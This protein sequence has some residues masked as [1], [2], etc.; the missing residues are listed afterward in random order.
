MITVPTWFQIFLLLPL[1]VFVF[2]TLNVVPAIVTSWLVGGFL[3]ASAR[4]QAAKQPTCAP[5]T[6]VRKTDSGEHREPRRA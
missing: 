4:N 3:A 2:I 6:G 5:A 1:I